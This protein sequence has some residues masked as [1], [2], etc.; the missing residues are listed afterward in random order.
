M[1]YEK[2]VNQILQLIFK[3]DWMSDAEY[4]KASS[5]GM[6]LSGIT[7]EKLNEDLKIGIKNGYDIETQ[8][9]LIKNNLI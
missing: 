1:E 5:L 6:E 3:E 9:S 2:E 8:I 7:K 4:E